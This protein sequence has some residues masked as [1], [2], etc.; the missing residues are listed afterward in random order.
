[1]RTVP[2]AFEI[3]NNIYT[4]FLATADLSDP[5]TNFFVFIENFIVGDLL[6][7]D[8][9]IFNQ[10]T[11]YKVLGR[12][13]TSECNSVADYLGSI[14]VLGYHATYLKPK[15]AKTKKILKGYI[16]FV[17]KRLPQLTSA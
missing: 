8:K 6:Y 2:F 10:E 3:R 5:P 12:L 16:S 14:A 4:G 1:M 11:R 7:Q 15:H 17:Y 9:W 13:N